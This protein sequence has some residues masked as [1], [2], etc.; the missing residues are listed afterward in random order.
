MSKCWWLRGAATWVAVLWALG[1]WAAASAQEAASTVGEAAEESSLPYAASAEFDL[2]P[3]VERASF[4]LR[5][6]DLRAIYSAIEQA[7]GIRLVYDRDLT[8]SRPVSSFELEDVTL[9]QAL[10][11]TGNISRTFV[12]PLDEHTGI[13]AADTAEKRGEY[14]RQVLGSFTVAEQTSAQQIAEISAALRSLLDLRRVA[15]DT[16]TNWISV[17]GRARQVRA[18]RQFVETVQMERGE[19]MVDVDILEVDSQ[20]ARQLGILP[21]QPFQLIFQGLTSQGLSAAQ[22]VP[23]RALGAGSALFA[24][25]LAGAS[26]PLTFSSSAVRSRQQLQMRASDGQQASLLVGD[27]VPILNGIVSSSFNAETNSQTT[28]SAITG[29]FPSIQYEDVGVTMKATPFLH[30]GRELTLKFDLALRAVSGENLN[31]APILS[32][33]Q[34]TEQLRM[35][36]GET[37]VVG[38]I[39]KSSRTRSVSGYP[40][41]S[42]LPLVGAL[43]GTRNR[44]ESDTELLLV[45]RPHVV[46]FSP[47]ELYA[48]NSVYFGK[49]LLGLPAAPAQPQQPFVPQPAPGQPGAPFQPG[50]PGFPTQPGV[51]PQPGQPI[52]PGVTPGVPPQPGQP[53]F[54]QGI[55]PGG[56]PVPYIPGLPPGVQP[57]PVLPQPPPQQQQPPPQQ[58]QQQQ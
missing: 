9:K 15:Q 53:F 33:N 27:R 4:R 12:A 51:F 54:P 8:S 41:L 36:D 44:Q 56:Q 19:V 49:E 25:Q 28:A 40:L 2:Q 50:Q 47:A 6:T 26:A 3:R 17:L 39:L 48:S 21:P 18:A 37:Y 35:R 24:V 34:L 38:G 57:Q 20:R 11:A 30:F 55:T 58:Q 14:E 16:R 10:D 1:S 46:R 32:N 5:H 22:S 43:F 45:I 31:G 29:F 7:Y 13:V 52:I 42:R 23:L